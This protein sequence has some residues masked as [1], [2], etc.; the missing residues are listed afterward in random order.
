MFAHLMGDRVCNLRYKMTVVVFSPNLLV[1]ITMQVVKPWEFFLGP[2]NYRGSWVSFMGRGAVSVRISVVV[3]TFR[4]YE[5]VLN[6]VE[7]LLKQDC[8]DFEVIVVDQSLDWPPALEIRRSQIAGHPR[9]QWHTLRKPGVVAARHHGVQNSSGDI[10][11][12]VDDDV[13]ITDT[14]FLSKHVQNYSD[15]TVHAVIGRELTPSHPLPLDGQRE[16]GRSHDR[17][18]WS[19]LS[20]LNQAI[21]FPR[22]SD[23]ATEVCSF[24]TC[25]GSVRKDAFLCVGGFDEHFSGNSYGDDYD[26]A[27]RLVEAGG[28]IVFNPAPWLIH[29]GLPSGGLRLSDPS[30]PFSERDRVLSGWIFYLRHRESGLRYYLLYHFVLRRS[31]LLK[32]NVFRPW[33]VPKILWGLVSGYREARCLVRA[34][35]MSRFRGEEGQIREKQ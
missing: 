23:M 9:V 8:A 16:D 11:F 18:S 29:L 19:E 31:L 27:I 5:P 21:R 12:F 28:R 7:D 20:L 3:P 6:T 17:R 35:P 34:G 26:F 24:C 14:G 30:N 33:R 32:R 15:R 25:N 13:K 4:R 2:H 1:L 10:L 22:D